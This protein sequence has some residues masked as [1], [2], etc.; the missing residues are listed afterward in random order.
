[1]EVHHHPNLEHKPKKFK[2][3]FL[4]FIMI[5]LAV[6]MGFI[7]EKFR[8][9]GTDRDKEKD[10]VKSMLTDLRSDSAMLKDEIKWAGL[11]GN[12]LDSLC[13]EM[14]KTAGKINVVRAYR[15]FSLYDRLVGPTF[16]DQT[17]SQLKSGG[18]R[19]IRNSEVSKSIANYWQ[20]ENNIDQINTNC[21]AVGKDATEDSYYIFNHKFAHEVGYDKITGLDIIKIDSSAC[22]MTNDSVKLV[23]FANKID[24][25]GSILRDNY[26]YYISEQYKLNLKLMALIRK[27]Y[28]VKD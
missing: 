1:M 21:R 28:D 2:E 25:F 16:S 11:L 4:E 7:A 14:N 22:F 12:G 15:L 27:E 8:E 10:Y 13:Q 23:S 18:M 24:D 19:L 9:N 5:F 26:S 20:G 17:S 6:M 3:Y